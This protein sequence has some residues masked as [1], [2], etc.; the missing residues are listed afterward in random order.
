LGENVIKT[1]LERAWLYQGLASPEVLQDR[2]RNVMWTNRRREVIADRW[3]LQRTLW[4][5]VN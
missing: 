4:D 5:K 1:S 3:R 2:G